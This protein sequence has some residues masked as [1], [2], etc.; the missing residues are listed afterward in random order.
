MIRVE[1]RRV[2]F[3]LPS[4]WGEMFGSNAQRCGH[5]ESGVLFPVRVS[6]ETRMEERL[7]TVSTH[8]EVSFYTVYLELFE[9]I[10]KF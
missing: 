3:I 8:N 6:G 5:Q 9:C 2:W 10:I 7:S 4:G 1:T